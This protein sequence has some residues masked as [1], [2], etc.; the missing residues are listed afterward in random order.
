MYVKI[1]KQNKKR[2]KK[3]NWI[4]GENNIYWEVKCDRQ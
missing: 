1:S 2:C 4:I 3:K